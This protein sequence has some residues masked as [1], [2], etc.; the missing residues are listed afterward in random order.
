MIKRC[1]ECPC[2]AKKTTGG[3]I[4]YSEVYWCM[5]YDL[6]K[7]PNQESCAYAKDRSSK[8]YKLD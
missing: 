1:G 2:I 4:I 5:K 6:K 7:D 3:P 8:G